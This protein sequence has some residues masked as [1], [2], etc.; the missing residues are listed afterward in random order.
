MREQG[1]VVSTSGLMAE[2]QFTK[3]PQCEGCH[4]CDGFRSDKN[5]GS[6][7]VRNAAGA[8]PGDRVE[9]EIAP[10][11][12]LTSAFMVF[13]FPLLGMA[14]GYAVATALLHASQ[15]VGV[16]AAFAGLAVALASLK[17]Y[18]RA[19]AGKKDATPVIVRK[20]SDETLN[21][22]TDRLKGSY[23]P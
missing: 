7:L 1:V 23:W 13:I 5:L 18:D 12:L 11:T 16:L 6:L 21:V 8:R 15:S 2:V 10:S 22:V 9:V 3:G 19:F 17:L 20:V 14:L 4:A